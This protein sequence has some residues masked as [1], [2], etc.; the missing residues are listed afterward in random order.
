MLIK[1][2]NK[3]TKSEMVATQ[4]SNNQYLRALTYAPIGTIIIFCGDTIPSAF[5]L[6]DGSALDTTEYAELFNVMG[7]TYGGSD[8]IFNIPNLSGATVNGMSVKYIIKT[9]NGITQQEAN[10]IIANAVPKIAID[11]APFMDTVI[12]LKEGAFPSENGVPL[13]S[14]Y[15][16]K[17]IDTG[18]YAGKENPLAGGIAARDDKGNLWTGD[19]IDNIDCTNKKYVDD[20]ATKAKNQS[21]PR[22]KYQGG[23]PPLMTIGYYDSGV[24]EGDSDCLPDSA[25]KSL[26]VDDG[27]VYQKDTHS[28][29]GWLVA[30]DREG[31]LWTGVP[32]D[33]Q[34]C[35]PYS[36]YKEL[37][38]RVKALEQ[39]I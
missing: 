13:N 16:Y 37:L 3:M 20:A 24:G 27:T 18:S 1:Q 26:L 7:Y 35:V 33:D 31:N 12:C 30:R 25:F 38:D 9:A 23:I 5:L 29:G 14:D 34:D 6:C 32:I 21:V 28:A 22:P 4:N 15:T 2:N 11:A 19:P 8:D 17:T 39:K 36:M 10:D